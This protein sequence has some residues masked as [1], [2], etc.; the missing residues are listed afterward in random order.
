MAL[1]TPDFSEVSGSLQPG[2]YNARIVGAD[3]KESKGG[4]PMIKWTYE[5]FGSDAKGANGQRIF[6]HTMLAGKGAFRLQDLYRSAMK[7]EL[8]GDF[9]TDMLLGKEIKLTLAEGK[10]QDG[11]PSKYPE[12][13]SVSGI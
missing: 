7:Q 10:T 2:M 8:A 4:V 3:V 13:K 11:S 12:V 9:D 1:V 5:V 6:D